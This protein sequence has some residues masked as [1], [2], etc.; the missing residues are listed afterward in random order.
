[1]NKKLDNEIE[2]RKIEI[3]RILSNSKGAFFYFDK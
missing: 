2:K 3:D 1:M